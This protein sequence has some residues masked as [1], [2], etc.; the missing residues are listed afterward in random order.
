MVRKYSICAISVD[1]D[2]LGS[3]AVE[4]VVP[5]RYLTRFRQEGWLPID[6]YSGKYFYWFIMIS[7]QV[8]TTKTNKKYLRCKIM[9][10]NGK[11]E[12]MN[13]WSWDGRTQIEPY[14]VCVAEVSEN[15]FGKSTRWSRFEIFTD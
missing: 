10:A 13:I 2:L 5:P 6:E 14:S 1:M 3:V 9:G 15:P 12:W 11:Q 8:R 4:K 7:T